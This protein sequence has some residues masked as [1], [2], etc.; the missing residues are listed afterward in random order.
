MFIIIYLLL[1]VIA[2]AVAPDFMCTLLFW[3]IGAAVIGGVLL[4]L[5]AV[6]A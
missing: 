3:G 6:V 5:V 2:F 1:V 4:A